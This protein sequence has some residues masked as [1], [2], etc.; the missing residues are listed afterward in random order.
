[1]VERGT[2]ILLI[3]K[4]I[5]VQQYAGYATEK[6]SNR[7][8]RV[9]HEVKGN[10]IC[11]MWRVPMQGHKNERELGIE[12]V[13]SE[14][15]RNVWCW[16]CLEAWKWKDSQADMRRENKV[17]Y[18]KCERKDMVVGEKI[19]KKKKRNTLCPECRTGEK[20]LWWN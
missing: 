16:S 1:M 11:R 19:L 4:S 5:G 8:E 2:G 3:K 6:C 7:E 17:R 15:L 12:I 10:D 13:S 20:K 9:E 14:H 18:M